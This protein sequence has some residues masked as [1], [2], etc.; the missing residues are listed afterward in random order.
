MS[1]TYRSFPPHPPPW[2]NEMN[3]THSANHPGEWRPTHPTEEWSVG[4]R[5][6]P[7]YGSPDRPRDTTFANL[8][9]ATPMSYGNSFAS[10][11]D[12]YTPLNATTP[13]HSS[14]SVP[15]L[16]RFSNFAATDSR[17]IFVEGDQVN[18]IT[19]DQTVF[20]VM[21]LMYAHCAPSALLD[22]NERYTAPRCAEET[23]ISAVQTLLN[24]AERVGLPSKLGWLRGPAGAGKSAIAQTLAETCERKGLLGAAFFFS[25]TGASNRAD[26]DRFI[27]TIASQ[28][29]LR[30][31]ELRPII[32]STI[33]EDPF[34]FKRSRRA[35]FEKLVIEPL[36]VL[37][38]QNEEGR[39]P[40][41][42]TGGP[43]NCLEG[44]ASLII[45]DGLDEC[46]DP[47]VQIDLLKIIADAIPRLPH[48]FRFLVV[49]RP[50]AHI[51]HIFNNELSFE[52]CDPLRLDLDD[53][54]DANADIEHYLELEFKRMRRQHPYHRLLPPQWPPSGAVK[55]LVERASR[56][57]IYP[58]TVIHFIWNHDD[59]PNLS[60]QLILDL[61][62]A[63][64]TTEK[65]L[66][67]L[68]ELYTFVFSKVPEK[69]LRTIEWLF[70]LLV[71]LPR[72]LGE[73][74]CPS[75]ATTCPLLLERCLG[76]PPGKLTIILK[77][78]L[79]LLSV[80]ENASEN[81]K[82]YHASLFDFL[83]DPSRRSGL[84][85][86]VDEGL[87]HE[88]LALYWW[89]VIQKTATSIFSH[90]FFLR[91]TQSAFLSKDLRQAIEDY[92]IHPSF[93]QSDG[94]S[95]L[96]YPLFE[97]L[98]N[99][100]ELHEN[101][102]SLHYLHANRIIEML[103]NRQ[104]DDGIWAR[105]QTFEFSV[106]PFKDQLLNI[107]SRVCD[108]LCRFAISRWKSQFRTVYRF[109]LFVYHVLVILGQDIT[110]AEKY[111]TLENIE[112]WRWHAA[113]TK[114]QGREG[115]LVRAAL[116]SLRAR[117][118]FLSQ[119]HRASRIKKCMEDWEISNSKFDEESVL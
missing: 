81:L 63:R 101:N 55:T 91:D 94:L 71:F 69:H 20:R 59:L 96:V 60:L 64:R 6:S 2:P 106:P 49:S 24:W 31:P 42:Q 73:I 7:A 76:L 116:Q 86:D 98:D 58:S 80:P 36:E 87:A 28:L 23:R 67:I 65:P 11:A 12:G 105:G 45:I 3:H 53:D 97:L 17:F 9:S 111:Y 41:D 4:D 68:D 22:S 117:L 61:E 93:C 114:D 50:E 85:F 26:G 62:L 110:L 1:A 29:L 25:R 95:I 102:Y 115:E 54:P 48:P 119:C 112:R 52:D 38:S 90:F 15:R 56:Q 30:F 10:D 44:T 8:Y 33:A 107:H 109:P 16:Y 82:I 72:N 19:E 100:E 103:E 46:N 34:F 5:D 18:T 77:P 79:S 35:Q 51:S 40:T 57:F 118:E 14:G 113:E 27:P 43:S 21:E 66:A 47:D 75:E 39:E 83:K 32:I 74:K 84:K 92:E 99:K 70:S 104:I 88:V 78:L 89:K 37:K 108:A 13:A